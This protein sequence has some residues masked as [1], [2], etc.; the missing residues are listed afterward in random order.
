VI[1]EPR[2]PREVLEAVRAPLRDGAT[3]VDPPLVQPLN[4]LLDLLG[5]TLR[6]HVLVVQT[7]GAEACLRPDFTAAVAREHL[8]GGGGAGRCFYEGPAFRA[9]P[10]E[11]FLQIGLELIGEADAEAADAEIASRAW[12][13]ASAGGRSDLRLVVGDLG[14]FAAFCEGVGLSAG[15][16]SRLRARLGAGTAWTAELERRPASGGGRLAGWLAGLPEAQAAEVL[17]E[18][19]ETNKYRPVGGR[20]PADIARRLAERSAE[21]EALSAEQRGWLERLVAIGDQ[22]GR[23]LE[24]V[25]RLARE[26]GASLDPA[27]ERAARRV[28]LLSQAG[29]G[30]AAQQLSP[31]FG[32]PFSYYDG[33]LFEVRSAALGEAAPVAAGG[34]Y[35]G[36]LERLQPGGGAPAV[37]CMVRPYRAWAGA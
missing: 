34:R 12:R 31:G 37:G 9:A 18:L 26:A 36:L 7:N 6:T 29:V 28:E 21:R 11:E 1:V 5:E 27:L 35:D 23:A 17:T 33:F 10:D 4:L 24:A 3:A 15:T 14:L 13:S 25:W 2:P 32:R 8:E 20:T 19:W 16:R 30:A 22:P